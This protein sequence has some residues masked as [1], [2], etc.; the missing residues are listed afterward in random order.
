MIRKKLFR[1]VYIRNGKKYEILQGKEGVYQSMMNRTIDQVDACHEKWGRVFVLLFNLHQSESSPTSEHIS[2]FRKNLE[3]RIT[4][5][6]GI[7]KIGF[8][9]GRENNTA[10]GQH[11]HFAIFLDGRKVRHHANIQDMIDETWMAISGKK[12]TKLRNPFY[13]IK[14][15]DSKKAALR[16]LS[17]I[18]KV[19]TKGGRPSD[20]R[21][22]GSSRIPII[23]KNNDRKDAQVKNK[24]KKKSTFWN[25]IKRI[26]KMAFKSREITL[27]QYKK[28][29]KEEQLKI[30]MMFTL[31]HFHALGLLAD[32]ANTER[33]EMN[34]NSA[35]HNYLYSFQDELFEIDDIK[36]KHL[37]GELFEGWEIDWN[38]F[39]EEQ[40]ID[41]GLFKVE[42]NEK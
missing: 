27:T 7:K 18:C 12:A 22:F 1:E 8:I 30:N 35:L 20:S 13:D 14:S 31:M 33:V 5:R 41:K 11:Y 34:I 23:V 19:R 26:I 6:Y 37:K 21:D 15:W 24:P 17:Y 9:W 16:R 25:W 38:K 40:E 39:I 3:R 42:E 36:S 32:E 4:R 29:G 28:L 2:R 10:Q